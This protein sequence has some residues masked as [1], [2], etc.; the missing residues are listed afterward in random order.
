[1]TEYRFQQKQQARS[2][3]PERTRRLVQIVAAISSAAFSA[4]GNVL[5]PIWQMTQGGSMPW[6]D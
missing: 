2:Q 1:M 6:S 4:I 5:L 3:D